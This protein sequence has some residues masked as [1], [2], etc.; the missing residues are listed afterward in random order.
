MKRLHLITTRKPIAGAIATGDTLVFMNS[1][2]DQSLIDEVLMESTQITRDNLRVVN[3][4]VDARGIGPSPI[5]YDELVQLAASNDS[6]VS[7]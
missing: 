1:A 6:V 2:I 3:P 7:W 4:T 5:N